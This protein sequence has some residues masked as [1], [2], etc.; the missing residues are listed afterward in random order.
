M[1]LQVLDDFMKVAPTVF[2]HSILG[3][4]SVAE[5][6]TEF[7]KYANSERMRRVILKHNLN[8][9]QADAFRNAL[10][11]RVS[12]T[13]G[14]PGTGKSKVICALAHYLADR[15]AKVG[16]SAPSHDAVNHMLD[17]VVKT[18]YV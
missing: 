7:L 17:V 4:T 1:L 5:R 3:L 13:K 11:H 15:S 2:Q 8:N 9:K 10:M 14:P 18:V 16:I 6:C 12:I